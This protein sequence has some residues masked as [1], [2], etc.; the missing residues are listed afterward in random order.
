MNLEA[1]LQEPITRW[2]LL[3]SKFYQA[4]SEGTLP[5]EALRTYAAE[6]GAF[7][8]LVPDGWQ[9][10]GDTETAAVERD[11]IGMWNDFA[12]ALGTRIGSAQTSAVQEL[13]ET[14]RSLFAEPVSS[15]GA[16][17]A[18]EAQQ[19]HTARTKLEGLRA[20]YDLAAAAQTYFAVHAG[21]E[22]EPRMLLARMSR[23]SPDDQQTA[24]HACEQTC[25]ALR[26]A[27]DGL[28]DEHVAA[29]VN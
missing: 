15:L 12:G 28:Y 27:L 23:L 9:R 17:Y 10:H 11:H 21:D 18:F 2:N 26:T 8:A 13:I 5:V 22:D 7:I 3:D 16:L 29:C 24:I 6:Y 1:R 14:A 20:H 4:W 25:R 19:P